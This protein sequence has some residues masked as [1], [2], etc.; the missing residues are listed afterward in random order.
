MKK[1]FPLSGEEPDRDRDVN[2]IDEIKE[3]QDNADWKPCY[4]DLCDF[5]TISKVSNGKFQTILGSGL[6]AQFNSKP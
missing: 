6:V 1:F 3:Q 2:L 5:I 4:E